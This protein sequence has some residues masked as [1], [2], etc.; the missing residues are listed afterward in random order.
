MNIDTTLD[1]LGVARPKNPKWS[2]ERRTARLNAECETAT[3]LPELHRF[4]KEDSERH[5]LKNEQ[6]WHRMA[7]FMLLAGRTNSEIGAAAGVT[8]TTVSVLRSQRWFQD[9]LAILANEAGS[10]IT[11]LL[12]SEAQASLNLMVEIRDDDELPARIRYTAAKDLLEL[13]HGKATQKV[14]SL[15]SHSVSHKSPDEE[16]QEIQQ[17]LANLRNNHV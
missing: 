10:D 17:E 7:A 6:P 14:V 11:G 13:S 5:G 2:P 9:L 1:V 16:M 4:S 3:G 12:A 15:V 8:P